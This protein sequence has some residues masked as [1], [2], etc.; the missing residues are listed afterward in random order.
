MSEILHLEIH[1]AADELCRKLAVALA[2][3]INDPDLSLQASL[4]GSLLD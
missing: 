3:V 1:E 4:Y 2:V